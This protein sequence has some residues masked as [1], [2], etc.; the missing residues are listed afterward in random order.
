MKLFEMPI[1]EVIALDIA[2]IITTSTNTFDDEWSSNG[3]MIWG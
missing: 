2:D 1:A 3:G